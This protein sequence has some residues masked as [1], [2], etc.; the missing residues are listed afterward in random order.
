MTTNKK[1]CPP[2]IHIYCP[3]DISK[4][5]FIYW[6]IGGKRTRKYGDINSHQTHQERLLAAEQLREEYLLVWM[7]PKPPWNER[8][9]TWISTQ[10]FR[11]KSKS[12]YKSCVNML[13]LWL[14]KA[15]LNN[16]NLVLFFQHLLR[17]KSRTTYNKYR[18]KLK[19]ILDGVGERLDWTSITGVKEN[20]QPARY[21]QDHERAILRE[22]IEHTWPDLLHFIE[23]MYYCF[24]RPKE[25]TRLKAGNVLLDSKQIYIPGKIS[26]NGKSEYVAI[27][28]AFRSQLSYIADMDP[29]EWLFPSPLNPE[30]HVGINTMWRRHD[31]ILKKLRFGDEYTLYSWKHTGAVQFIRAGGRVKELQIQLRH[32]SLDQVNDYLRQMGV[33]DLGHLC[34]TFPPL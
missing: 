26:K 21:F 24:I 1:F 31:N 6:R 16:E 13:V 34:D 17:N 27:P 32:H 23:F 9:Y 22:A 18:Q 19:Q 29:G 14:G 30:R 10:A 28:V 25:L 20:R 5:A 3:E 12:T 33:N 7:P 8:A 11:P 2:E 4:T 15:P